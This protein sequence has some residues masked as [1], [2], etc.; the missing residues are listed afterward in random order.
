MS[1]LCRELGINRTQYNRYLAGDSF[2]R[3]D[4]LH[5]ICTHFRVDSRIMLERLDA[6]GHTPTKPFAHPEIAQFL[7]PSSMTLNEALLPSGIYRFARPSFMRDDVFVLSLVRIYR[8]G[9]QPFIR[10]YELREAV[11][12]QGLP[13]TRETR[14]F[15]GLIS[16]HGPGLTMLLSRRRARSVSFTF[17]S[18]QPAFESNFWL[19]YS[20][21]AEAESL[22]CRRFGR[23]VMEHLG[24]LPLADLIRVGRE[25]GY[26]AFHELPVYHQQL[27]QPDLP[28]R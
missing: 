8:K 9:T 1:A 6:L 23:L 17:L 21:R 15:R 25:S 22:N 24:N 19:G 28:L 12:M 10:G 27:L 3:P 16:E 14:E 4:V 7:T 11:R 5:K 20:T 26:K 2:P 18:R 13:C